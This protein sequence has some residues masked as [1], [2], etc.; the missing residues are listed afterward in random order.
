MQKTYLL[1]E[2]HVK[3]L[4]KGSTGLW[5]KMWQI[6]SKYTIFSCL[7]TEIKKRGE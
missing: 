3:Q 2:D 7:H 4:T 5:R 6:I 1:E